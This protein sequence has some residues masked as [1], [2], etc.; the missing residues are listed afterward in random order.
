M[1]WLLSP[2][3]R[4]YIVLA[5]SASL[6]LNLALVVPSI[7]M[8][9][10]FDRVFASRSVE[11]LVMLSLLALLALGLGF[12]MD[13]VRAVLLARAGHCIDEALSPPALATALKEAATGRLRADRSAVQDI[14]RLRG[15]LASPAVNAM[16]DAPWLPLYLLVIFALHPAL[17]VAAVVSALALFT[18]G[19]FTERHV[20]RDADR[21]V[22]HGRIAA[23]R[24]EALMRNAEVLVGMRMLQDALQAWHGAHREAVQ[25]QQ[26]VGDASAALSALGRLLRQ[27]VQVGMLGLGAWLVVAGDAS[28]GIMIASTVLIGRA[29]QPVEHLISGWKSLVEVRGAWLRLQQQPAEAGPSSQVLLP[30]ARGALSLE[31]VTLMAGEPTRPALIKNVSFT[32]APGECLGLIGPSAA[33]KTTLLR[34]LLGL[35]APHAGTVRLDGADLATW[36]EQQLA[37]AVGYLP[38][39]VELFAGSVAHNIARL[40]TI[41]SERVVAAAQRAG[42]HELILRLPQGYDT[43]LGDGGCVLSGGQRQRIA[44]ARAM[45]GDPCLVVLDEPNANLDA[46][47]EDALAAAI[48][49]LKQ[50]GTT[51]VLVSHRPALMQHV[52]RL[53]VLRDGALEA[54]GPREQVLARLAHATVQPLRRPAPANTF[55]PQGATA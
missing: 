28:P 27:L 6:L 14:A 8:L 52:D 53:A 54:I 39:D 3:L 34:L 7:Y 2:R 31:H 12:C 40:G 26:R 22:T 5:A 29:L 45:Y 38:Q 9:E 44:L 48:A 16:F 11:T 36:P 35:R 4:P 50:Q 10:V 13:R 46:E 47:G 37:G 51:V 30:A 55:A 23:Q 49:R 42:V 24:I 33:G 43:E 17:G 21:A 32:L 25:A 20:R 19:W 41:D 18:L 15:F 1:I